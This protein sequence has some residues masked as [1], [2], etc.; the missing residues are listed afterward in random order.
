MLK[1]RFKDW[2]VRIDQLSS[3]MKSKGISYADHYA[4]ITDWERREKRN[5]NNPAPAKPKH[6]DTS[7][8]SSFDLDEWEEVVNKQQQ[9]RIKNQKDK[10]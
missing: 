9:Q 3:Y 1:K 6:G 5:A 8:P 10:A 7:Q 2:E 4:T